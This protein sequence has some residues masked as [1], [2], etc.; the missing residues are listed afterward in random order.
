M[1]VEGLHEQG[2]GAV[3]HVPEREDERRHAGLLEPALQ[4]PHAL[5]RVIA[6]SSF[7]GREHGELRPAQV[8]Q[9][10]F[11]GR[12]DSVFAVVAAQAAPCGVGAGEGQA[13]AL[14]GLGAAAGV[15]HEEGVVLDV[16][17]VDVEAVRGQVDDV[18]ALPVEG[19]KGRFRG[20]L[21]LESERREAGCFHGAGDGFGLGQRL[22][23]VVELL[24][25]GGA[26]TAS[27]FSCRCFC[28]FGRSS[29]CGGDALSGAVMDA[30]EEGCCP[31]G[32]LTSGAQQLGRGREGAEVVTV[33]EAAVGTDGQGGESHTVEHGD[34]GV[35]DAADAPQLGFERAPDEVVER[36]APV[37]VEAADARV[38]GQA[39]APVEQ[40]VAGL[41]AAEA[42]VARAFHARADDEGGQRRVGKGEL[43]GGLVRGEAGL[44]LAPR[45]HAHG[46]GAELCRLAG[47]RLLDALH[48]LH[49]ADLF[50]HGGGI[51]RHYG[52]VALLLAQEVEGVEAG[53]EEAVARTEDGAAQALPGVEQQALVEEGGVVGLGGQF[54]GMAVEVRGDGGAAVAVGGKELGALARREEVEVP[55]HVA[56]DVPGLLHGGPDGLVL[57]AEEPCHLAERLADLELAEGR[58]AFGGIVAVGG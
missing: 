40:V 37:G 6:E 2:S 55:P 17:G 56:P 32:L 8:E 12:Q 5:G 27:C 24:F 50:A 14:H 45:G 33:D 3:V 21:S 58:E 15:V 28:L 38:G 35:V 36:R 11:V 18:G 29:R 26:L 44:Y 7:A 52:R 43:Y 10:E 31:H 49:E 57:V 51:E 54:G 20:L 16:V 42:D 9:G 25:E 39:F 23:E 41:A 19:V 53:G 48:P 22:A 1:V 30:A 13:R 47:Q 4:S 46:V 34:G